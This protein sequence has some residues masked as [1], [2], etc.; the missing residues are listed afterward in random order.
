MRTDRI[1][2]YFLK[3]G[4]GYL[5]S[6]SL[7]KFEAASDNTKDLLIKAGKIYEKYIKK[8][9]GLYRE[10]DLLKAKHKVIKPALMWEIGD[11]IFSML[12]ELNKLGISVEDLYGSLSRDLN[13]SRTTIKRLISLRRYFKSKNE[14]PAGLSW[15]KIKDAPKRYSS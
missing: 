8:M 12:E 15:G 2:V 9:S 3:S 11:G 14:I 1:W 10:R 13:I 6:T 7:D 4:N 5:A